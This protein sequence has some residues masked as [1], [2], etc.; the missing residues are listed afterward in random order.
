ME[1][2]SL[3]KPHEPASATFKLSF[4]SFLT[5]ASPHTLKRAGA[6]LW[7]MLCFKG[8]FW[9][10]YSSSQSA[11]TFFMSTIRVICFLIICVFN[12]SNTFNFLQEFFSF[13][14]IQVREV[15]LFL[16]LERFA[17][18]GLVLSWPNLSIV[19]SHGIEWPK[20]MEG[21]GGTVHPWSSQN[22][23]IY[24][25]SL[26]LIWKLFVDQQWQ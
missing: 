1:M 14:F 11:K 19:V 24:Q 6:F 2:A 4:C 26:C 9:L 25:L 7:I 5:S 22:T 8:M 16:S 17:I 3:P 21:D 18:V 15:W 20:K 10:F 13:A 23:H 12:Q